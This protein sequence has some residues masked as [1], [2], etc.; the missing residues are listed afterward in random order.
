MAK[1]LR[2][3]TIPDYPDKVMISRA[4]RPIYYVSTDSGV[5]GK[6]NI[7]PSF[8]S[9]SKY[10]FNEKGILINLETQE[11][12]LA[13]PQLAGQP[14]YWVVNFQDIWNGNMAKQA[15]AIRIDKLKEILKPY[16]MPVLPIQGF[17]IELNIIIYDTVC[18]V[19][20]S[21]RGAVYTKVIEDLLVRCEK[22]P[23]D[24]VQYVNCS[25][26]IKYIRVERVED[27]KMEILIF[28]SDNK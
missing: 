10:G 12:K 13:N 4:R 23:D 5:K 21:N 8:L 1:L 28:K 15:R 26:R 20:I 25:G 11:P 22:I 16:I 2:K 24:S 18:P 19:D 3:I 14:R 7:P 6:T 9:G 27:K 17:P